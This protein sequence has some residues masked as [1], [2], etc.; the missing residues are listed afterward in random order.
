M[1]CTTEGLEALS[2]R[3]YQLHHICSLLSMF[4]G[5]Q[6]TSRFTDGI[7]LETYQVVFGWIADEMKA[8][9]EELA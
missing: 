3:L 8:I 7:Q 9:R 4:A 5:Q 1:A 6:G 2:Y